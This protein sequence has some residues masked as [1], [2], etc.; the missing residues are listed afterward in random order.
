[1]CTEPIEAEVA[2]RVVLDTH[3]VLAITGPTENVVH[4]IQFDDL[5]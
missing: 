4:P 2:A 1:M 5:R 3:D